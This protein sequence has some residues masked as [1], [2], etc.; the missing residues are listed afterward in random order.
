[1][2]QIRNDNNK[3]LATIEINPETKKIDQVKGKCNQRPVK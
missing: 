3:K 2:E 1:M